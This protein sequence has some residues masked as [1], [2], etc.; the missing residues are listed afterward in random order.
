MNVDSWLV[1]TITIA[2]FLDRDGDGDPSFGAQFTAPARVEFKQT[3]VVGPD[4]QEVVSDTRVATKQ[5]IGTQDRVW[6]PGASTADTNAARLALASQNAKNHGQD[7][8]LFEV[9]F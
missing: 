8:T 4:G 9:F 6:L 2:P 7:L 1:D 3:R 5:S